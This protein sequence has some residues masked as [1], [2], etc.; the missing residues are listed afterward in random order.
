MCL[1]G[2]HA[3]SRASC[4]SRQS[5]CASLETK[6]VYLRVRVRVNVRV[7]MRVRGR[8]RVFVRVRVRARARVYVHARVSHLEAAGTEWSR[9]LS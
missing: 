3:K 4:D 6:R 7:R 8:V 2:H 1:R 5:R 9:E